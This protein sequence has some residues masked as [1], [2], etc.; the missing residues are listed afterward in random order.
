MRWVNKH[1]NGL[2]ARFV[3][4]IRLHHNVQSLHDFLNG[5]TIFIFH[6]KQSSQLVV[7]PLTD[8]LVT[9][10]C[11]ECPKAIATVISPLPDVLIAIFVSVGAI[12]TFFVV[13]K[14][15]SVCLLFTTLFYSDCA[16]AW[17]NIIVPV[18]NVIFFFLLIGTLSRSFIMLEI[19]FIDFNWVINIENQSSSSLSFTIQPVTFKDCIFWN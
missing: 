16:K 10:L 18:A 17:A 5:G 6:D 8:L 15:P 14:I 12:T 3:N 9:V 13:L 7:F 19:T 2:H 11:Y 1:S 4:W